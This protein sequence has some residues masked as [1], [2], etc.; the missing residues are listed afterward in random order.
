MLMRLLKQTG[1]FCL[2]VVMA[3]SSAFFYSGRLPAA[4]ETFKEEIW[5]ERLSRQLFEAYN[6]MN[7]SFHFELPDSWY[8]HEVPMLGGE[9]LY[10]LDFISRDK[11]IHGFVQVWNL[12]KPLEQFIAES[13]KAATGI[14]D[15]KY[16]DVK[17]MTVD[18][19]KGYLMEYSRANQDGEY[20]KAYEVFL[21]G[22][23]NK[24]YRFS[25]FVPEKEWRNYYKLLFER[26][27][28]T[29]KISE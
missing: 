4:V 6:V 5:E 27:V 10:H 22:A 21:K 13:E 23:S 29:V 24:M 2:L 7:D 3:V 9:I 8:A 15:Y 26:I 17:E 25:F 14:V 20:N 16:Y 18:G 11:R 19:R 28:R 1:I 12:T